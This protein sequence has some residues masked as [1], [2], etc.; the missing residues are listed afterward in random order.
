MKISALKWCGSENSLST[1]T[2]LV[3]VISTSGLHDGL[4]DTTST[5][6]ESNHGTVGG[7][8][9]LLGAGG[10]LDSGPLGVGVVGDDG[11]V[12]AG[13]SGKTTAI[14]GLLLQVGDDGTLRHHA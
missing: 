8:D 5:S 2:Y 13:G 3:L 10:K 4:V 11:G 12:V 9:D 7:G 6:D 14:S 1:D